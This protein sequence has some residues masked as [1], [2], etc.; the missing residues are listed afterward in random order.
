[1]VVGMTESTIRITKLTASEGYV[2]TNGS[3]YGREVYLG[4]VDKADNWYEITQEEYNAI[5]VALKTE[6]NW[7]ED[8]LND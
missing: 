3:A 8:K 5:L 4:K 1:M 7:E 2:L 6:N